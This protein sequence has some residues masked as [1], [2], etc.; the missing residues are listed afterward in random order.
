[1]T[2]QANESTVAP[3]GKITS[4][5]TGNVAIQEWRIIGSKIAQPGTFATFLKFEAIC[6]LAKQPAKPGVAF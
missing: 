2:R 6:R 5:T 1:M 3:T 4:K